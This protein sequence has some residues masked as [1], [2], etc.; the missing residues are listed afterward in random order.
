MISPAQ[1]PSVGVPARI[2]SRSGSASPSRSMPE[3]HRGRLA[4]RDHQRVE[5]FQVLGGA[6]VAGLGAQLAEQLGVGLEAALERQD[7][8]GLRA[9]QPRV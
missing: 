5:P 6:H 2:R 7:A 8:D 9:H 4:A 3:R 1:V